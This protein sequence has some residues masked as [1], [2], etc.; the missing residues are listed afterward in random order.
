M[1]D[2]EKINKMNFELFFKDEAQYLYDLLKYEQNARNHAMS[3]LQSHK[4]ILWRCW[5]ASRNTVKI[6][7]KE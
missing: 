1:T 4:D 2:Q 3:G 6:T 5:E 7:E